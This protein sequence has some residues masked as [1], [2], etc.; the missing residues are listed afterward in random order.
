MQEEVP[1]N[2][3][4]S[5]SAENMYQI[6][7][8]IEGV[9]HYYQNS[10]ELDRTADFIAKTM[11][12]YG[13]TVRE[14]IFFMDGTDVAF[15][16]IEGSIGPVDTEQAA[17]L[18]AHY[19][20]VYTTPGAND[21]GSGI[22][23]LLETAKIIAGLKNPPPVYF[24][25]VTLEENSNPAIWGP[26][27]ESGL[28][29][30]VFDEE[31]NYTSWAISQA[32][33]FVSDKVSAV[34]MSGGTIAEGYR[35]ALSEQGGTMPENYKAHLEKIIP[36]Y[37]GI[38][39]V[40]AIGHLNRIGSSKWVAEAVAAGKKLAFNIAIDEV[41]IYSDEPYS[42]GELLQE[43]PI[44]TVM[45]NQYRINSDQR[46]AN[47]VCILTDKNSSD[48]GSAFSR[49]CRADGVEMPSG[50]ISLPM[51]FEEICTKIP[52]A[53]SSD[54]A[55]FWQAG[56]PAIFLF[57]TSNARDHW[58]HS[59]ADTIERI[60][61]DKLAQLCGAVI[62]FLEDCTVWNEADAP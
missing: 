50:Q 44:F 2:V 37:V 62:R 58:V 35:T 34:F 59:R 13:L 24:V 1:K 10:R 5:E 8:A 7:A 52:L 18:S 12:S 36:L 43:M 45:K 53:L 28:K 25:A 23:L 40:S 26:E 57:D 60:D 32:A 17:V 48:L 4:A 20:T 55:C 30:G 31:M 14:Q 22:A 61:F 51:S 21:D 54:H 6:I 11:T 47:F 42:Q 19:D 49:A 29:H 16:N 56:I 38:D 46:L 9:R 3:K 41:G 39:P 15:R 27:Y 33:K